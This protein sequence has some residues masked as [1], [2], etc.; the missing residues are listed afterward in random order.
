[1]ES[2]RSCEGMCR[3]VYDKGEKNVIISHLLLKFSLEM[4][5]LLIK[6]SLKED[7]TSLRCQQPLST[8]FFTHSQRHKAQIFQSFH[9]FVRHH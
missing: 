6:S 8:L 7:K 4:N 9:L 2:G 3:C 1:M 5:V